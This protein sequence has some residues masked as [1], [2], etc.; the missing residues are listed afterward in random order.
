MGSG[1]ST[2]NQT[3]LGFKEAEQ[4]KACYDHIRLKGEQNIFLFGTSMGAAAI[5]KA[6]RDYTI[7]ASGI[8]LEC[9]FGSLYKTICAR[10]EIMGIPSFPMASVLSF[11]G[12]FQNDFWAFSHNPSEY[13]KSVSC[14]TLLL[15]GEEDNRV[16]RGEI[17]AIFNNL[18]G[19]KTL[20]TYSN[21]GHAIYTPNMKSIW[22]EDV[23]SFIKLFEKK[24]HS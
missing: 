15:Y 5:L 16:S 13:A 11:W 19:E 3:T 6:C 14:P 12:G 21:T 17:N 4:V 8:I 24:T 10:F 2:G 23:S 7:Q 1:G 9:P 18:K 22:I 20:K